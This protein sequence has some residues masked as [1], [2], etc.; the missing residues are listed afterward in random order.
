MRRWIPRTLSAAAL[1]L[2]L[3]AA[4]PAQQPMPPAEPV[5]TPVAPPVVPPPPPPAAALVVVDPYAAATPYNPTVVGRPVPNPHYNRV[6]FTLP[7]TIPNQN[8][9]PLQPYP[10]RDVAGHFLHY[11]GGNGGGCGGHGCGGGCGH[12][13]GL[14]KH[15]SGCGDPGGS[16][17][18]CGNTGEF[19]FGSSRIYFGES[20]RDFFERPPSV[21]GITHPYKAAKRGDI[22]IAP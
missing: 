4:A 19:I 7:C 15:K 3:A 5:P 13:L 21:D 1:G 9:D 16:C 20:S 18:T 6:N 14:L 2:T 12:G 22:V 10:R 17:A 8:L 11:S